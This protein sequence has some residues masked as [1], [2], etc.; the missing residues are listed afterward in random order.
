MGASEYIE[1][2]RTESDRFAAAAEL[3]ALDVAVPACEDWDLRDLVRHLGVIHL[4][5]AANIACPADDGL[6]VDDLEVLARHWPELASSWRVQS[7]LVS[8]WPDGGC[9]SDRD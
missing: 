2:I 6:F 9:R 1:F 5:A 3:G 8:G 4:W 7:L